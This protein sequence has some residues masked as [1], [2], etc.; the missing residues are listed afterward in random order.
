[1][2]AIEICRTAELGGHVDQC[3]CGHTR[4][5]YNSCRNRHCPKCQFLRK[6]KWIEARQRDLLPI[7]YFHVVFTIPDNLSPLALRN[8]EGILYSIL[9]K[10]TKETLLELGKRLGRIGFICI[11]HTWG[12]R[13]SRIIPI[14]TAS[15]PEEGYPAPDGSHHER[16]SFFPQRLCRCCLRGSS[17]SIS[18][19]PM[20]H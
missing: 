9:F 11:L 14:S 5:S 16:S 2:H 12:Q 6:E 4:I 8:Q 10:A 20:I 13:T 19:G 3:D 1:M 18:R 7:P 17:F 15:S